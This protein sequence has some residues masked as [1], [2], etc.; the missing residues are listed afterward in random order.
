[1]G[2]LT[3]N[4]SDMMWIR[5]WMVA[6]PPAVQVG[7]LVVIVGELRRIARALEVRRE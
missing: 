6:I 5:F 7:L 2:M 1:M 4:D 3:F